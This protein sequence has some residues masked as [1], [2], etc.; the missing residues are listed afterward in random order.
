[1]EGLEEEEE[2]KKERIPTVETFTEGLVQNLEGEGDGDNPY[3]YSVCLLFHSFIHSLFHS[4]TLSLFH[5][6]T[7]TFIHSFTHSLF[8]S[9]TLSLIHSFTHSLT[10]SF[11]RLTNRCIIGDCYVY[12]YCRKQKSSTI[13][14][15]KILRF[16]R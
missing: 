4:F 14:R 16:L 6:F 8:H 15:I 10:H 3:D 2:V 9:F 11:T 12:Y 1:M 7:L 13:S 5:S